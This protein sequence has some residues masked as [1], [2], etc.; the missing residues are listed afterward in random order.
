MKVKC[1][2]TEGPGS[3]RR[4]LAIVALL[5][6]GHAVA[7]HLLHADGRGSTHPSR[8]FAAAVSKP[9]DAPARVPHTA[10]DCPACQLQQGFA[11]LDATPSVL[12][13]EGAAPVEPEIAALCAA[14]RPA[15]GSAPSR[16]PPVL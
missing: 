4:C 9:H 2:R 7:L 10:D 12:C 15:D 5:L 6:F 11:F 16:A 13:L 1:F 8:S 3:A 14:Q